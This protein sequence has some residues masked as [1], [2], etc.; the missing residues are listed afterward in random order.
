[1]AGF[2]GCQEKVFVSMGNRKFK[3]I[4]G[5]T[6]TGTALKKQLPVY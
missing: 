5:G 2:S 1:M 3:D 6:R 4:T